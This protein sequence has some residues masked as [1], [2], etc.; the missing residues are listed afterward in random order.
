MI[1]LLYFVTVLLTRE[2]CDFLLLLLSL[3]TAVC[4]INCLSEEW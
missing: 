3:C 1:L 4:C 2:L